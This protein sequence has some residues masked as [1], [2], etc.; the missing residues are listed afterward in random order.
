MEL[1]REFFSLV[2][3][4]NEAGIEYAVVGGIALAFHAQPR[5][6]KDIDILAKPIDLE[7][8]ERILAELGYIKTA[9]PWTFSNTNITLH[10]FGKQ[11]VDD[12]EELIIVNLLIGNEEIHSRII[13]RSQSDESAAGKVMLANRDDLIWMKRQRGSKQDEADIEKLEDRSVEN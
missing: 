7:A 4:L 3:K 1:Y 11:S 10:R 5:F 8:Y 6:T 2:R 9:M 13:E 12:P